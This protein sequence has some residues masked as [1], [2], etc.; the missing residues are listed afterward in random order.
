MVFCRCC[1]CWCRLLD[2]RNARQHHGGAVLDSP[3]VRR[4]SVAHGTGQVGSCILHSPEAV[5]FFEPGCRSILVRNAYQRKRRGGATESASLS[6]ERCLFM[7]LA[8]SSLMFQSK[9][10]TKSQEAVGPLFPSREPS[11][12]RTRGPRMK[13]TWS[14]PDLSTISLCCPSAVPVESNHLPRCC[15]ENEF[16]PTSFSGAAPDRFFFGDV[17]MWIHETSFAVFLCRN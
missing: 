7:M 10:R 14:T 8:A 9:S 17:E 13:S 2:H 11:T 6:G 3:V 5:F 4:L 12:R 15:K 16:S 1:C